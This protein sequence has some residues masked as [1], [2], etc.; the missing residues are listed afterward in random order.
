MG[1]EELSLK[2]QEK[3]YFP[4]NLPKDLGLNY[5]QM[6][7]KDLP[8]KIYSDFEGGNLLG[9]SFY[10]GEE[11]GGGRDEGGGGGGKR[12]EG[13]EG[14]G[15]EKGKK[16]LPLLQLLI[17]GDTNS[18]DAILHAWFFFKI[19]TSK[20]MEI[21]IEIQN[22]RFQSQ[23]YE[24]GGGIYVF[25][26]PT[27]L[28]PPPPSSLPSPSILTSPPPPSSLPPPSILPPSFHLSSDD[29]PPSYAPTLLPSSSHS[30]THPLFSS[31]PPPFSSLPPPS[32]SLPPPSSS[33]QTFRNFD[34][35]GWNLKQDGV[36]W[37][38]NGVRGG[39]YGSIV[40]NGSI[41]K[42][43]FWSLEFDFKL[44]EGAT[45]FAM[46]RPYTYTDLLKF[47]TRQV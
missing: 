15:E 21:H 3:G 24:K 25:E 40:E 41:R 11:S 31:L 35:E 45:F 7:E 13:E 34:K 26:D 1:F 19:V 42:T 2:Y 9:Y 43:N 23:I 36:F 10:D 14:R 39:R 6:L 32:S 20:P 16:K 8:F 37:R 33:K 38:F 18:M 27:Y 22:L 29:L 4:I 17:R 47:F 12:E 30:P 44:N 5:K 28:P 46:A